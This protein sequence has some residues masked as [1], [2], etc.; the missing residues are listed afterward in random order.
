[1][2]RNAII[3]ITEEELNLVKEKVI[4]LKEE[5]LE[6]FQQLKE[7]CY[8]YE[9]ITNAELRKLPVQKLKSTESTLKECK[10]IINILNGKKLTK[11]PRK[12]NILSEKENQII[13]SYV[14]LDMF[15]RY[16][17]LKTIENSCVVIEKYKNKVLKKEKNNE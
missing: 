2:R 12:F 3:E 16:I 10:E 7:K 14:S 13:R 6:Q 1:M 5:L 9:S 11:F 15:Y 17:S 4:N 8:G